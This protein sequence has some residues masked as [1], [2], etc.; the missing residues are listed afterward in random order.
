[1]KF[2]VIFMKHGDF[3]MW[4]RNKLFE[5]EI[6]RLNISV[7]TAAHVTLRPDYKWATKNPAFTRIYGILKGEGTLTVGNKTIPMIP[8]NIYI[9]PTGLDFSYVCHT[10]MEKVFFHVNMLAYNHFDLL[11]NMNDCAVFTQQDER[12]DEVVFAIN[13]ADA[14]AAIQTKSWLFTLVTDAMASFH[15]DAGSIQAYSPLVKQA[16]HYIEKNHHSGL[17]ASE[18]AAALSISES[19]LQKQFRREMGV[20]LG[21]YTNDRLFY[22]AEQQLRLSSLSIKEISA[23]LGFCDPF[24]FS[25]TFTARYGFS[26]K[27]YRKKLMP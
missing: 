27:E 13:N 1:M 12:L 22:Y 17:S 7:S 18:I 3:A 23:Q 8:G 14:Y 19:R 21:R 2:L 5:K 4:F 25:R 10:A 20:P 9:L 16:M 11:R 24:Y 6:S 26:P 15:V